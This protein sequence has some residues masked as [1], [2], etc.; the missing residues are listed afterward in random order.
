MQREWN[1]TLVAA[2][3]VADGDAI[4]HYGEPA[5]EVMAAAHTSVVCALSHIGIIR[6]R[7]ADAET[8]LQ[9]QLCNDI[10]ANRDASQLSGYCT[11]QGRLIALFRV[12]RYGTDLLLLLPRPL[13]PAVVKRLRMFVLRAKVELAAA[14][15]LRLIGISGPDLTPLLAAHDLPA[16]AIPTIGI[17]GD[18]TVLSLPAAG[19]Q[20]YLLVAPVTA[21]DRLW[22]RLAPPLTPVGSQAWAWTDIVAGLPTIT[23][24]TAEAFVPQMVNLDLLNGV[25]FHKGCYPGQEIVARTHYL[26]RLKQRM[27]RASLPAACDVPA[28]GAT[29]SAANLPGQP[30]GTVVDAQR[31]P[32]GRIDLLAVI[33]ISSHDDGHVFWQDAPLAFGDLPYPLAASC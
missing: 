11:A 7:G 12:V 23:G 14:E 22:A 32:D 8:F 18:V 26:G 33:Q 1:E 28:P 6:A 9:G 3:G 4:L 15:E 10:M 20:R 21:I 30:A 16:P 29:L 5:A 19:G 17:Q 2:G 13:L 24:P 31:G 25:S 27:Y